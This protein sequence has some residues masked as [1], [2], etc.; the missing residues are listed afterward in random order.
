MKFFAKI[1]ALALLAPLVAA[2]QS[3][4][5]ATP[6]KAKRG[7][8]ATVTT[9]AATVVGEDADNTGPKLISTTGG[10]G[11][12]NAKAWRDFAALKKAADDQNPDALYELGINYLQGTPDTPKNTARAL[13]YLEDAAR[14]GHC[15]ANFRLGKLYADGA[16]AP[17]DY[18][19]ALAHYTAAARAGDPVAQHNLGAMLSSGRGVKRDY[20][21]GLAWL[22]LAARK[23]NEA[24]GSEK[25]LREF[26]AKYPK[27]IA[28]GETRA[29]ELAQ[30]L[31]NAPKAN[32]K[33][34]KPS[35]VPKP[36]APS[37]IDIGP[38]TPAAPQP[39]PL[40]PLQPLGP[41]QD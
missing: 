14:L 39:M 12:S 34:T 41:G 28:A 6:A 2:A 21:E 9:G 5:T 17:Q 1:L 35:G 13:L 38:L 37:K 4:D 11:S 18:S 36:A 7:K 24:A 20:A 26:L 32:A 8:K 27:V 16:E 31:A 29:A 25:K 23:N 3:A 15:A 22:I 40:I 33:T 30:E 19:K 10:G